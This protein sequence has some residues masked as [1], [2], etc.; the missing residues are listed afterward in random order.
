MIPV[1]DSKFSREAT[2]VTWTL[3]GLN[4]LIFLWDRGGSLF[5]PS[6]AFADL[7][8]RPHEILLFFKGAGDPF[9][10]GKLFTA[11]F[12]HGNIVHL[13]GNLLFLTTFGPN[14]EAALGSARFALYY[15]FW[16]VLAF[17][18]QIFVAPYSEGAVIG[19]SGA[20]GGVLG[21]Y[22]LLFP[23]NKVR[24]LIPPFV[25]W[26]FDVSAFI[27][28]GLWFI[29]QV[30]LPQEGVATWAHAGG[31]VGGMFTVLVLGGR[32]K[33]L[34]WTKFEQDEEFDAA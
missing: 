17:V 26:T 22:F 16:G 2:Y 8:L 11:M 23:G 24:I 28:L 32:T 4:A 5:G 19:A 27:L 6:V 33:V 20:I 13:V 1:R 21:A 3:V 12:L 34:S 14:V 18:A 30:L 25:W 9:D 29:L 15:V 31:F 7:A 10:L